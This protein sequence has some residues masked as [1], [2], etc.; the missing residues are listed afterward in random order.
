MLGGVRHLQWPEFVF[1]MDFAIWLSICLLS[2]YSTTQRP[3]MGIGLHYAKSI[4]GTIY[5]AFID[6]KTNYLSF[7]VFY[8]FSYY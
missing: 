3:L 5:L 2:F 6:S 7:L 4:Y 8:I 1:V